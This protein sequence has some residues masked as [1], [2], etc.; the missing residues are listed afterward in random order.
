MIYQNNKLWE[1]QNFMKPQPITIL[2]KRI[3]EEM[4]SNPKEFIFQPLT[5]ESAWYLSIDG[6]KVGSRYNHGNS[7]KKGLS[8]PEH[9]KNYFIGIELAEKA[10]K[11]LITY[12]LDLDGKS[13]FGPKTKQAGVVNNHFFLY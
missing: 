8:F 1:M 13:R 2:S 10:K 3:V 4:K 9:S 5:V 12:F 11:D 6:I 7:G